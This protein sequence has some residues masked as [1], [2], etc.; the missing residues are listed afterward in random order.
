MNNIRIGTRLGA[1]FAFI[2]LL[3]VI[4]AFTGFTRIQ[5]LGETAD[6]LAGS[7]YQKASTATNLR[8]YS[9]DLSRLVRNVVLTSTAGGNHVWKIC[10]V[11]Q[12]RRLF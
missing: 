4:V 6:T 7:R 3:L 2:L 12:P 8:Y 9:T 11:Q 10:A 1:A 5:S